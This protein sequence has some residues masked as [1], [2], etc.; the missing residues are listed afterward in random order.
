[1]SAI[2]LSLSMP[3]QGMISVR[4]FY[5]QQRIEQHITVGTIIPD[6]IKQNQ[7]LRTTTEIQ[8]SLSLELGKIL[9]D[10]QVGECIRQV[11]HQQNQDKN[12]QN[13]SC[14]LFL[15][16]DDQLFAWPWECAT[17]PDS[18]ELLCKNG[19]EF[20]RLV[21][22]NQPLAQNELP[23]TRW[24]SEAILVAPT[25]EEFKI[26]ALKAATRNIKNHQ[27]Q[28][29]IKTA[30][31]IIE[32]TEQ[33]QK[34][35]ALLHLAN[36]NQRGQLKFDDD[37][38]NDSWSFSKEIY[39]M[40]LGDFSPSE[41]VLEAHRFG[42]KMVLSRQIPLSAQENS[43]V[44]RAVYLSLSN[45][46]TPIEALREARFALYENDARS[47]HW[48]SLRLSC[49]LPTYQNLANP[50]LALLS[51]NEA[52]SKFPPPSVPQINPFQKAITPFSAQT[53][54]PQ[55][56]LQTFPSL[57]YQSSALNL[58]NLQNQ[59]HSPFQSLQLVSAFIQATLK[60]I[61][62]T[63][64][65]DAS[66]EERT[67]LAN[68]TYAMKQLSHLVKVRNIQPKEGLSKS[69]QLSTQLLEASHFEDSHLP[70]QQQHLVKGEQSALALCLEPSSMAEAIKALTLSQ[71]IW[72]CGAD[73]RT[74]ELMARELVQNIYG[75]FP[76]ETHQDPVPNDFTTQAQSLYANGDLYAAL[77]QNWDP[78]HINPYDPFQARC[79][80]RH[81]LVAYQ[82]KNDQ[83]R[84][85]NGAWLIC[86]QAD[87]VSEPSRVT[88]SKALLDQQWTM[89]SAEGN[90]INMPI[91]RDFRVI[92]LAQNPPSALLASESLV[93]LQ[94]NILY[95]GLYLQQESKRKL[96]EQGIHEAQVDQWLQNPQIQAYTDGICL[97]S[98]FVELNQQQ[99][100]N[101]LCY[102]MKFLDFQQA[103]KLYLKSAI[104]RL[105]AEEK[106][107]VLSYC[108]ADILN[109]IQAWNHLMADGIEPKLPSAPLH[110]MI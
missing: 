34:G 49:L 84:L 60:L 62:S 72:I 83:W 21:S 27:E 16:S 5:Q 68:R 53:I 6:L 100:V 43:M 44:D 82:A 97:L 78:Q 29:E 41:Q 88:I 69:A 58:Q 36:I 26:I 13:L 103:S 79:Q 77:I 80:Q 39:W 108:Q 46:K 25:S 64:K 55:I 76:Y 35:V 23:R 47:D 109:F 42:C 101:A 81:K 24:D 102:A 98:R 17:D 52:F 91:P 70:F 107:C 4:L 28:F 10:G 63:Q 104:Q 7:S 18:Q 96:V 38:F 22:S 48:A 85:V 19:V 65:S 92:Y 37:Y 1:M 33:S 15:S 56:S 11:I 31:N 45:G 14:T 89:I 40:I 59:L 110:W 9:L 99:S 71:S 75:Y 93:E 30:H 51:Q 94:V 74:R 90:Q 12:N 61:Q 50:N 3:E 32:L 20:I 66:V 105:S 2:F 67:Q 87:Q 54:P 86:Q 73:Q 57:Q 106:Q 95:Q 8:K